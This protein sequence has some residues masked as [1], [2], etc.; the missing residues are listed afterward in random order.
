M[1][2]TGDTENDVLGALSRVHIIL[3]TPEK[4]DSFTRKWK[5]HRYVMKGIRLM[6]IDEVHLLNTD[7]GATLEA[8]VARMQ[9]IA[10]MNAQKL[11]SPTK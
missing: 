3:T 10:N 7:R 8:I 9:S 6:M 1:E 11:R 5:D 4:W 2:L